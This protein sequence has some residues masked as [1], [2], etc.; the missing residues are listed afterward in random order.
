MSNK[1]EWNDSFENHHLTGEKK[2]IENREKAED[3]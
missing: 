3:S 1:E 2:T